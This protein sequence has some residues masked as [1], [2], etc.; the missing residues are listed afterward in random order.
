M[1]PTGYE[2]N[3]KTYWAAE[4][5][6]QGDWKVGD[7][8]MSITNALPQ[9]IPI[10][11]CEADSPGQVTAS[12]GIP[13]QESQITINLSQQPT[14]I[15]EKKRAL[16][17]SGTTQ[18]ATPN[19]SITLFINQNGKYINY[20]KIDTDSAGNYE[21]LWNFTKDGTYFISTAW[22]GNGTS[23]GVDSKTLVAFIGPQALVQFENDR[24]NY[25][26]GIPIS[27]IAIRR[28]I[29]IE[30]FLNIPLGTN[31]SV[32]YS[33]RV[34]QTG[35]AETGI[36]TE[37]VTIPA[38]EYKMTLRRAADPFFVKIPAKTITVPTAI[39]PGMTALS[40]PDDFNQTINSK[41]CLV[42]EEDQNN[43]YSL[44]AK[45]LNDYDL[46]N[47]TG[48]KATEDSIIN[49]TDEIQKGTIY[50]VT[51]TITTNGVNAILQ[52]ENGT[53][54]ES[55]SISNNSNKQLVLL[56]ANNVDSAVILSDFKV[57]AVNGPP[58]AHDN[59]TPTPDITTITLPYYLY[60]IIAVAIAIA[61]A[62]VY[63]KKKKSC[64]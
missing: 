46:S 19:S 25:I 31:V 12:L 64:S 45:G 32:S 11:S 49:A 40:L 24:G 35:S 38:K 53:S 37:N 22:E 41:F 3:N 14:A 51:A 52:R 63:V 29:G 5:T 23:A 42:I 39:P 2:Y 48:E 54:I 1:S 44:N 56:I 28:F 30:D 43:T 34:L 33:F 16:L 4:A 18:P 7:Q 21:Y 6:P 20:T 17:I 62:V 58:K 26:V 9:I 57:G 50:K 59:P 61:A 60:S 15:Q 27:D 36:A 8:S 55:L 13:P 47:L 10:D